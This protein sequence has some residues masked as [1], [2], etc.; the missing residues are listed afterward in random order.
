[1]CYCHFMSE[2]CVFCICYKCHISIVSMH[3][4]LNI[5]YVLYV[6]IFLCNVNICNTYYMILICYFNMY[7][8]VMYMYLD[9]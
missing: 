9:I 5:Q 8:T 2:L 6:K 3:L 1:M 7:L 4:F